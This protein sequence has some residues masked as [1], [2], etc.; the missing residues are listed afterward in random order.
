MTIKNEEASN[1]VED[2]LHAITSGGNLQNYL[3]VL[4]HFTASLL[5]FRGKL[6]RCGRNNIN[7]DDGDSDEDSDKE[8]A[9]SSLGGTNTQIH[10]IF[11]RYVKL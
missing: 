9:S 4:S 8:N 6:F 1:N 5:H 7:S 11:L 10:I 3:D 2:G